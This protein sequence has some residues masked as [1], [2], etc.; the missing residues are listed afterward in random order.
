MTVD[1]RAYTTRVKELEAAI[2]T[3]K[4]LMRQHE[5]LLKRQCPV[6]PKM[7]ALIEP[8]K[9]GAPSPLETIEHHLVRF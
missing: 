3:Q 5:M 6:Q 1:L 2:Y 4:E 7:D 8:T 9:P